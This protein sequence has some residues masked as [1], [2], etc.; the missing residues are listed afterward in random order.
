MEVRPDTPGKSPILRLDGT[1]GFAEL[2]LSPPPGEASVFRASLKG[3]GF[4]SSSLTDEHFHHREDG[5]LYIKRAVAD[6]LDALRD[7]RSTRIE[8][9]EAVRGM[10]IIHGIY[11]LA[12]EGRLLAAEELSPG[13]PEE[14]ISGSS[15]S[16]SP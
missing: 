2:Q 8:V 11:Q 1:E 12:K 16:S 14:G 7:G 6:V 4:I 10:E 3:Q 5:A 13:L 9:E 15:Q